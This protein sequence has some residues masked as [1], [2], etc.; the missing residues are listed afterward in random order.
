M[1]IVFVGFID[2]CAM[3]VI[4]A[5]WVVVYLGMHAEWR[6]R[7]VSEIQS[8]ISTHSDTTL[9]SES[10]HKQLASIPLIIIRESI[11]LPGVLTFLFRNVKSDIDADGVRIAKGGFS[12]YSAPDVHMNENIY[13]DPEKF[14]PGRYEDRRN[15]DLTE[16][17]G[18]VGFGVG[19]CVSCL[20]LLCFWIN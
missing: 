7:T 1:G 11:R 4:T 12:I 2:T 17:L 8:M 15:E 19:K 6:Q 13:P 10:F 9:R 18:Y 3:I 20:Y 5:R 16:P 14:D